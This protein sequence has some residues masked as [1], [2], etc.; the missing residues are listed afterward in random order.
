MKIINEKIE[1]KTKGTGDLIN[2]TD[3]VVSIVGSSGMKKGQVTVF[4]TGS[5]PALAS[6]S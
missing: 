1:L 6:A 3:K 4:V 5:T 2:I